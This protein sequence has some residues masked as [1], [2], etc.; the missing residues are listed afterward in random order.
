MDHSILTYSQNGSENVYMYEKD[1][2]TEKG[3]MSL[4]VKEPG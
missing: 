4:N 1:T 3:K 2:E